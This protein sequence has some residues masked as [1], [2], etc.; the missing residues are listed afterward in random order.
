VAATNRDPQQAVR[1]GLLREDLYYR[2]NVFRLDLPPLRERIEDI[3]T[4]AQHFVARR[5]LDLAPGVL[6]L[7]AA[8]RWPGNV[9]EL[10]N[11]LERAAIVC[12]GRTIAA[13]HLPADISASP[14]G[15]ASASATPDTLSIPQAT[16]A[17]ERQM[18][19]AALRETGGNKSKAARLLDISE[20]SLWYKLTRYE[21]G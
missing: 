14:A 9:R 19:A 20:R 1:D 6:D 15:P 21:L 7:L 8:Y 18:I 2:L 16:E 13:A 17:L 12:G 11:V 5:G 4:L 10:E 3:P